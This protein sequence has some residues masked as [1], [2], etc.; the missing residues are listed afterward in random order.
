LPA[1]AHVFYGPPVNELN[2]LILMLV[3]FAKAKKWQI[4]EM[5]DEDVLVEYDRE[6]HEH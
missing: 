3:H 5:R 2:L 6:F 1:G 4:N